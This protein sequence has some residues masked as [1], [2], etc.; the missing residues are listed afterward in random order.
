MTLWV[1]EY[2]YALFMGFPF[3]KNTMYKS[4]QKQQEPFL[5]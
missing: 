1:N 5:R 4:L 2:K 3:E